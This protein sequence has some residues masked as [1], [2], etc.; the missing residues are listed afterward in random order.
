[1]YLKKSSLDYKSLLL[2]VTD[3]LGAKRQ[4][5]ISK[6]CAELY[7]MALEQ[8][9]Y[10]IYAGHPAKQ[11]ISNLRASDDLIKVSMQDF[12]ANRCLITQ[13]DCVILR[14]IYMRLRRLAE[15]FATPELTYLTSMKLDTKQLVHA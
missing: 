14:T 4:V 13:M 15:K 11:K 2:S 12:I 9:H 5:R 6:K 1:M 10:V 8:T 7:Q 3:A